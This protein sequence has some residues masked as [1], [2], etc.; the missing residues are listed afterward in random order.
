[1][2]SGVHNGLLFDKYEFNLYE[3]D[4]EG[5]IV[6][7]PYRGVWFMVDN[8]Y[9]S[10]SCTVPPLKNTVS[11]KDIRFSQ[12]LESMRKDVE[13]A[14]GILKGRFGILRYGIRLHS[15][16]KCDQIWKTCCALHNRL[17][18]IDGLHRYWG[19]DSLSNWEISHHS[20]TKR[21]K[22]K[23]AHNRL[24]QNNDD[25]EADNQYKTCNNSNDYEHYIVD[26]RR[27]VKK[28]PLTVF[29]D[30]LIEYFDV[31][32]KRHTIKWPSRINTQSIV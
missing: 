1:M 11:Y 21:T 17:L 3:H 20:F 19:N 30:R 14:F 23:F 7:I 25:E 26:G 27:A 12:W 5:K 13:C 10:W 31:R 15:I 8:S 24:N 4:D 28:M 32:F 22:G 9:L 18:F 29:Q 16:E 2:I 6:S